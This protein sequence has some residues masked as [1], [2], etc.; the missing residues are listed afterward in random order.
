MACSANRLLE[1][2]LM[3]LFLIGRAARFYRAVEIAISSM[4]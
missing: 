1:R 4:K 2:T 3:T